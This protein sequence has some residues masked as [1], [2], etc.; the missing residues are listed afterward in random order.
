MGLEDETL[1]YTDG[2]KKKMMPDAETLL[3]YQYFLFSENV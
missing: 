2:K 3:A 1:Q